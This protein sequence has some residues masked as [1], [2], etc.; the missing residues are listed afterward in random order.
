MIQQ[1]QYVTGQVSDN[2]LLY[3]PKGKVVSVYREGTCS[4]KVNTG[5]GKGC[6]FN[7]KGRK[8]IQFEISGAKSTY[9]LLAGE[10][11][12]ESELRLAERRK[13]RSGSCQAT[14]DVN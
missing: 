6:N 14:S 11:K 7:N 5:F 1:Y 13:S 10:R 4:G 12:S 3:E 2:S 8:V 9:V